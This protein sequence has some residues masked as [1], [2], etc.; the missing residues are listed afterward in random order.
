MLFSAKPPLTGAA[1]NGPP[2]TNEYHPLDTWA[3]PE[4][5]KPQRGSFPYLLT[6]SGA[7]GVAASTYISLLQGYAPAEVLLAAPALA[8]LAP[9]MA[10]AGFGAMFLPLTILILAPPVLHLAAPGRGIVIR[11]YL[12]VCSALLVLGVAASVY[13]AP[14]ESRFI[15]IPSPFIGLGVAIAL[16]G[17][18]LLI[19]LPN[20]ADWKPVFSPIFAALVTGTAIGTWAWGFSSLFSVEEQARIVAA[21]RPYC[22]AD[23]NL[24]EVRSRYALNGMRFRAPPGPSTMYLNFHGLLIVASEAGDQTYNWSYRHRRFDPTTDNVWSGI[25]RRAPREV[26]TPQSDFLATR[27]LFDG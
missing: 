6:V 14:P 27:P 11:I 25:V 21:G 20:E 10:V 8:L 1:R 3:V 15:P 26:C 16:G 17:G 9:F 22:I 23:D 24:A 19:R 12:A 4:G 18:A 2:V 5:P 13:I 7:L